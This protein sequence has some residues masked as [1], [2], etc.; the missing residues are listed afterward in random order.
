MNKSKLKR[1]SKKVFQKQK[2]WNLEKQILIAQQDLK[3]DK[4]AVKQ[5]GKEEK[6]AL[7]TTKKLMVFLFMNCTIIEIYTLVITTKSINMGYFDFSALNILISAVVGQV[8]AFAVYA[9]KSLK[10][11]TKGGI[12]YQSAMHQYWQQI[13]SK[14]NNQE[15]QG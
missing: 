6:R 13:D 3:E 15:A 14:Q 5:R 8:I 10:E 11:N 9:L 2:Q 1:K 12:V 7:S 4:K